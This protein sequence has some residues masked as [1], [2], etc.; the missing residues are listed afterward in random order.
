M[1]TIRT[2]YVTLCLHPAK[3]FT[4]G[5]GLIVLTIP[6]LLECVPF[7]DFPLLDPAPED[8]ACVTMATTPFTGGVTIRYPS[9]L[10]IPLNP[11][12]YVTLSTGPC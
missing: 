12:E 10:Y 11:S 4:I 8:V 1:R 3:I 7:A 2:K 9:E 5:D 6:A